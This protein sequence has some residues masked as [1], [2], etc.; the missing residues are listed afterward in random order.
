[1]DEPQKH[2]A[3]EKKQKIRHWCHSYEILQQ[4]KINLEW[5]KSS[6]LWSRVGIFNNYLQRGTRGIFGGDENLEQGGYYIAA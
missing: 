6:Q 2:Y 5:L 1:M 4:A 3:K